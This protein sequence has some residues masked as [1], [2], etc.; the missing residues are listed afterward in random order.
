MGGLLVVVAVVGVI[1]ATAASEDRRTPVVVLRSSVDVGEV[2]DLDDVGVEQAS[3]PETAR[4]QVFAAV[5]DV[6][7]R[8]AVAPL[9]P[10]D[11][12]Q[13]TALVD[14]SH[15][16][17]PADDARRRPQLSLALEL[18]HALNG[19]VRRGE[20]VDVVATYGSGES[21]VTSVVAADAVV[22]SIDE[23][24]AS[25]GSSG[26][27]VVTLAVADRAEAL[28]VAHAADAAAVRLVQATGVDGADT[29]TYRG[30][31]APTLPFAGAGG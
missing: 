20:S 16:G 10:G 27:V 21:A 24:T 3:L 2:I 8:I 25:L 18:D 14:G 13:R 23:G 22:R 15:V 11:V 12:A 4:A 17:E 28:A 30:P 6:V 26:S 5:D 9:A 29:G 19:V 7:G 31:V 1:A